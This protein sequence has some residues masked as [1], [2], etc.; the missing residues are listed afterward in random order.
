[1]N[2][3]LSFI[4]LDAIF[5]SHTKRILRKYFYKNIQDDGC[6]SFCISMGDIIRHDLLILDPYL[7]NLL[8][9]YTN[10]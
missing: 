8:D 10:M 2:Y 3:S 5:I 7:N 6:A 4:N 9:K 1:M